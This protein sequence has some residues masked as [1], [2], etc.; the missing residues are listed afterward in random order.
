MK[1]YEIFVGALCNIYIEDQ[2]GTTVALKLKNLFAT[3]CYKY[4]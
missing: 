1:I 3:K 2:H 4:V